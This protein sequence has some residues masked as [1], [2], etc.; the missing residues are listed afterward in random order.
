MVVEA[1]PHSTIGVQVSQAL[2]LY[3]AG[4]RALG[5]DWARANCC[6]FA[7]GWLESQGRANPMA[8]LRETRSKFAAYRLIARLGGSL[9]E[10]WT[11]RLGREPIRA[12]SAQL[13]DIVLQRLPEGG[14]MV[15]VC[16]GIKV[17][18]ALPGGGIGH[19]PMSEA[20]CAWRC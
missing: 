10:A 19:W 17:A 15:G 9:Q 8:G 2:A 14:A 20:T 13:G 18:Y 1:V 7:A 3:C 6:H 16:A 11:N 5:F 4:Y 12:E